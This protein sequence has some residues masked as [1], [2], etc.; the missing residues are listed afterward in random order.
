MWNP[1][2]AESRVAR[3]FVERIN[4]RDVAGLAELMDEHHEFVD[5][6]GAVHAGREHMREGWAQYFGAFPDYAVEVVQAVGVGEVVAMFGWATGSFR[7]GVSPD[8]RWRIP[9]AWKAVVRHE[10]VLKW[11]VYCDVEPMLRSM[12]V[13]RF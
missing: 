5:A 13:K 4:A 12:G 6:T 2:H 7:G 8:A 11:S 10:R 9:A 1:D 3:A